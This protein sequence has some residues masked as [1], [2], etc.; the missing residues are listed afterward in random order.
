MTIKSW[1][2]RKQ[3]NIIKEKRVEITREYSDLFF[4]I[5]SLQNK[6]IM[7]IIDVNYNIKVILHTKQSKIYV[8]NS[9]SVAL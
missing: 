8:K 2:A 4:D 9:F 1:I 6:D 5:L 3:A 7:V